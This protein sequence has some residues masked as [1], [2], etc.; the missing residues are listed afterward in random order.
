MNSGKK[1]T[2]GKRPFKYQKNKFNDRKGPQ[3]SKTSLLNG[4]IEQLLS[5]YEQV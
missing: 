3:V 5:S 4:E 2:K 1:K